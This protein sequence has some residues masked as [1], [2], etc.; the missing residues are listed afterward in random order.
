VVRNIQDPLT[1]EDYSRDPR[2]VARKAVKYMKATGVAD[3]AYF[4]PGLEFFVFDD[5]RYGQ[6]QNSGYYYLDSAEGAWNTGR[7]E[8]PN[9]GYKLRYEEG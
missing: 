6:T 5:D 8:K 4:G 2:N 1:K 7:Q 9:L 3:T